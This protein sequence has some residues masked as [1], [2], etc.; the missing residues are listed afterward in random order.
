MTNKLHLTAK[1][2]AIKT[3]AVL[4]IL[5]TTNTVTFSQTR[6]NFRRGRSSA[7]V[8]GTLRAGGSRMYV[9]RAAEGQTLYARISSGNGRVTITGA[10]G[11]GFKDYEII[12][13]SGDNSVGIYNSGGATRFT[14]T[15]IIR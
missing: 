2:L 1:T 8:S 5:V 15:V 10:N 14:L 7:T 6:I 4:M 13:V 3:F 12:T 9:L 11:R